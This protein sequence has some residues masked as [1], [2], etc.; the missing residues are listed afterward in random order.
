MSAWEVESSVG[1][2]QKIYPW[3]HLS[4]EP[5]PWGKKKKRLMKELMI[6]T[7]KGLREWTPEERA[8]LKEEE[9]PPCTFAVNSD[10]SK[11]N[12]SDLH[13]MATT[14]Q[15]LHIP[16]LWYLSATRRDASIFFP[17][18]VSAHGKVGSSERQAIGW[19][20]QSMVLRCL[21]GQILH[22]SYHTPAVCTVKKHKRSITWFLSGHPLS[23]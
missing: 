11:K 5:S 12:C 10:S 18:R 15:S 7:K 8:F 23:T 21:W 2:A 13:I 1:Q 19:K 9:P 6:H 3:H 22:C 16:F 17:W 14:H 4:I 20:R